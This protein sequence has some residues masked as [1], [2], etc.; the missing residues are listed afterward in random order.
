MADDARQVVA[1][2]RA[3]ST[4]DVTVTRHEQIRV[5]VAVFTGLLDADASTTVTL[6]GLPVNCVVLGVNAMINDPAATT[7]WLALDNQVGSSATKSFRVV[8]I[9]GSGAR[10]V[11]IDNV[12][13]DLDSGTA[14]YRLI[15]FWVPRL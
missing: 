2:Y 3:I 4:D 1:D 12:G 9:E 14:A 13:T 8:H 11:T 10:Q 7:N 6:S 5:N 15:I